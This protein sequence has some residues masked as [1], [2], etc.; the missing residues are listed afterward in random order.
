MLPSE[1]KQR[2]YENSNMFNNNLIAS[3]YKTGDIIS[4][5]DLYEALGDVYDP[6]NAQIATLETYGWYPAEYCSRAENGVWDCDGIKVFPANEYGKTWV[7]VCS[8]GIDGWAAAYAGQ[9]YLYD[10]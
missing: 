3:K 5:K 10:V 1:V 9:A 2:T 4:Y 7:A 8:I 6:G